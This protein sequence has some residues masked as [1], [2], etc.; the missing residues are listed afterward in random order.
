MW[1]KNKVLPGI[2]AGERAAYIGFDNNNPIIS[3]VVKK[4]KHSKFCHLHIDDDFQNKHI[5]DLFFILMTLQ[6]KRF[7]KEVHFTLP[8]G[9]WYRKQEFFKSFGFDKPIKELLKLNIRDAK[10]ELT[11]DGLIVYKTNAKID[12]IKKLRF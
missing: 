6:V 5:G 2:K 1:L 11:L 9:L 10:I 4:D 12:Q 8:E 3:S 7:A